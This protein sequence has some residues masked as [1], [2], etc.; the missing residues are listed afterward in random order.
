MRPLRH[1]IGTRLSS[2]V[3]PTVKVT[4]PASALEL[5][6]TVPLP[7]PTLQSLDHHQQQQQ[8]QRQQEVHTS[9]ISTETVVTRL[10]NGIRVCSQDGVGHNVAV[11][12]LVEVGSRFEDPLYA[13]SSQLLRLLAFKV[14]TSPHPLSSTHFI[15]VFFR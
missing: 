9:P 5:P 6:L 10:P 14:K 11:G 3:I 15:M 2:T 13:G 7:L 4:I 8:V 12:V 1:H